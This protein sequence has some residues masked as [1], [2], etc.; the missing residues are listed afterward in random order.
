MR[1]PKSPNSRPKRQ[2]KKGYYYMHVP[3]VIYDGVEVRQWTDHDAIQLLESLH[4]TNLPI[5]S[6]QAKQ[7]NRLARCIRMDHIYIFTPKGSPN[8]D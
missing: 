1:T 7:L 6:H 8:G 5:T 4:G 2:H 3:K